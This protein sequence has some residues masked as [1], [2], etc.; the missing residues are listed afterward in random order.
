MRKLAIF[1]LWF[2]GISVLLWSG[3]KHDPETHAYPWEGVIFFGVVLSVEIVLLGLILRPQNYHRSWGR[4]LAAVFIFGGVAFFWAMGSMH[5][6][7]YY[8]FHVYWLISVELLVLTLLFV[9][10]TSLNRRVA[11][12]RCIHSDRIMRDY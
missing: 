9:S 12:E 6:P 2:L 7:I 4:A 5:Q 1:L 10:W 3:A 11:R 8:Q